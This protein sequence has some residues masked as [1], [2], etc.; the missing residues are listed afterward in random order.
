L[1]I[2]GKMDVEAN[3]FARGQTMTEYALILA[4]VAVVVFAGY[5]TMGTNVTSLVNTINEKL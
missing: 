1:D 4:T 3:E 2:F 5:Q